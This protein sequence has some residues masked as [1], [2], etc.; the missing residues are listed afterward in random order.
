MT[1]SSE[2]DRDDKKWMKKAAELALKN[3]DV[4]A[5]HLA[6]LSFETARSLAKAQI[7]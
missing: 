3:I 7:E 4:V 5:A 1:Q 6:Q 2:N